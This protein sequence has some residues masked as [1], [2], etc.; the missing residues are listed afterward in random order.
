MKRTDRVKLELTRNWKLPGKRRVANWFKPSSQLKSDLKNSITWL[1]DEDIAI[2]TS[3][4]NYI[5]WSIIIDGTYEEEISKMIRISLGAGGVALDIGANIGLQSIRMSQS[6]GPNGKVYS[7]E[8]LEYI[9]QKF[10]KN[11]RLNKI[12]NVTLF[13]FALSNSE[14]Q[15][16]LKINKNSW[17]Q[18]T[19][20]I[21]STNQGVETQLI[22]IKVADEIPEI[23]NLQ[24]LDLVKI[25]VEGFE[26][27]VL[28]G[29]K[30]TIEKFSP[31][32]VFEYDSN[33]WLANGQNISDCFYYLQKLN[34]IIYQITIAGCE[35]ISTP[36]DA[37]SG[38]LFCISTKE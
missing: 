19:F 11:I 27:Q 7:F 14:S 16:E 26:N 35:L 8:P 10:I 38:N 29:L 25:D 21:G 9:Q 18:G 2:Y 4:D 33:Y 12:D 17:N 32:I 13:P 22:T 37:T 34:Y 23:K 36:G 15:T 6:V 3:A 28:L 20:T 5:E 1:T 31:R 24:R 30:Q